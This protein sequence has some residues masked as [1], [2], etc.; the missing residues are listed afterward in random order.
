MHDE[1][2]KAPYIIIC[3]AGEPD[4]RIYRLIN[5][6]GIPEVKAAVVSAQEFAVAASECV[7]STLVYIDEAREVL[8]K[9]SDECIIEIQRISVVVDKCISDDII[10]Q[11]TQHFKSTQPKIRNACYRRHTYYRRGNRQSYKP[12]G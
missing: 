2:T 4:S 6:C 7:Q 8:K 9:L 5:Q 10:R 11:P 3:G 1:T 12:D